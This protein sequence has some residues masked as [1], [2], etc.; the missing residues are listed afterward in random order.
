MP[1]ESD[2]HYSPSRSGRKRPS[3]YD[4][5]FTITENSSHLR[6]NAERKTLGILCKNKHSDCIE[7]C[8]CSGKTEHVVLGDYIISKINL[9]H[10]VGGERLGIQCFL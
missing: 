6:L 8:D 9:L 1:Q 3:G 5:P 4:S 2:S 7:V 10:I